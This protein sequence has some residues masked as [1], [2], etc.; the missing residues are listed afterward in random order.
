M[1]NISN[2]K[3]VVVCLDSILSLLLHQMNLKNTIRFC[4][5]TNHKDNWDLKVNNSTVVWSNAKQDP[6]QLLA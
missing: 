3:A 1:Q 2:L 4:H 6:S 5:Q